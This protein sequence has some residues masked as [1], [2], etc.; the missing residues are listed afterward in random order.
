MT[1]TFGTWRPSLNWFL[2][3]SIGCCRR[4]N[5]KS[6]ER[7]QRNP[8][9]RLSAVDSAGRKFTWSDSLSFIFGS[10]QKTASIPSTSSSWPV[11]L[12]P[13]L[14]IGLSLL[15]LASTRCATKRNKTI[16]HSPCMEDQASYSR[17]APTHNFSS[18]VTQTFDYHVGRE[19]H[20]TPVIPS[21]LSNIEL[22]LGY[23]YYF[24]KYRH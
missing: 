12:F 16:P 10:K 1:A 5:N 23:Y 9:S 24:D 11:F 17:R 14:M 20:P 2:I 21:S 22:P 3:L 4:W 7:R 19:I 8:I 13:W 18:N 15:P 6:P